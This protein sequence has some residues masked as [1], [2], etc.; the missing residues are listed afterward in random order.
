MRHVYQNHQE[1]KAEKFS[2]TESQRTIVKRMKL[3][4]R[5]EQIRAECS[6]YGED[7]V[8][9]CCRA[10]TQSSIVDMNKH[11]W[12]LFMKRL[13]KEKTGPMFNFR[14]DIRYDHASLNGIATIFEEGFCD[15]IS[16]TLIQREELYIP[17][18]AVTMIFPRWN[19]DPCVLM[20]DIAKGA[21]DLAT[22]LFETTYQ[23]V[24]D[25]W[26]M[27]ITSG[28]SLALAATDNATM[29]ISGAKKEAILKVFGSR[30]LEA[31]DDIVPEGSENWRSKSVSMTF[32]K[33]GVICQVALDP[34]R[35]VGLAKMLYV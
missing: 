23:L 28:P 15:S 7:A 4:Q 22:D 6:P 30:V 26:H 21:T 20:V 35:A 29:T 33:Q 24:G 10:L 18:A 13:E 1:Q 8:R 11:Q 34:M 3:R 12:S 31:L 5:L 17:V 2:K 27:S 32:R 19:R 16:K 25:V 9:L 14:G